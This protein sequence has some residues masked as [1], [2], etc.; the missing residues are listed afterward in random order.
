LTERCWIFVSTLVLL[1]LTGS[2]TRAQTLTM[3]FTASAGAI[4][5]GGSG[6]SSI[7][8]SFGNVQAFG[9]SVP[10][11]VTK[12]ISAASWNLD[13]SLDVLVTKSGL[14]SSSY[15]LRAQLQSPDFT[16]TWK[17]AGVTL[18]SA[19]SASLNL[20]GSYGV[21]TPYPFALTIP[22]AASAATISNTV[23]F[24]AVAN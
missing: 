4:A 11:G 13:T 9:G 14:S 17:V 10:S 16:D 12:S 8:M 22:F 5:I 3:T 20:L 24:L 2:A 1:H 6:T 19:S 7:S 23:N 18:S 15:T 21:K